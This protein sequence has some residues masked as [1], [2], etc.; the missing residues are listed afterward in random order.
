MTSL[1]LKL[2][3]PIRGM[4]EKVTY[5]P[6][7]DVSC[8]SRDYTVK[9]VGSVREWYKVLKFRRDVF[10][11]E[12]GVDKVLPFSLDM[13]RFDFKC[14]SLMVLDKASGELV[15]CYRLMCSEFHDKFYSESEFNIDHVKR[16]PGIKVELGRACVD[17]RHRNGAVIQMLWRGIAE[18]IRQTR[19]TTAFGCTSIKSVSPVVA[20][21]LELY[22]A[23]KGALTQWPHV[24][25]LPAFRFSEAER[26]D[27]SRLIMLGESERAAVLKEFPPLLKFYLK[28]GAKI[29]GPAAIDRKFSCLDFFTLFDFANLPQQMK[30]K[31][32]VG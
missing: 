26:A 12:Y 29:C 14:D 9:T 10:L 17:P 21:Q 32:G 15:G 25:V 8:E 20:K 30:E 6:H 2:S 18:Y 7:V 28:I 24:S 23:E 5:T 22:F 16:M 19:A 11:A 31:Y 27:Q 13:D 1:A 4:K 3:R